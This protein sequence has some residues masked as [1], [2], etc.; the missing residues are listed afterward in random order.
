M[1]EVAQILSILFLLFIF[2]LMLTMFCRHLSLKLHSMYVDF[3]TPN[4]KA[5]MCH[6]TING[7][8]CC[9]INFYYASEA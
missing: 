7:E 5:T 3:N 6:F 1:D 2:I 9:T 4:A 8:L